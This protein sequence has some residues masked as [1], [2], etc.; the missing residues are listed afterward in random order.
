[1]WIFK[2]ILISSCAIYPLLIT[3][4]DKLSWFNK[5]DIIKQS[6]S[7]EAWSKDWINRENKS[8]DHEH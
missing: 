3:C 6:F 4:N 5:D 8:L 1:M 7:G 2:N